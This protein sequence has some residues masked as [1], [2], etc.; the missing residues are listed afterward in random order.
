MRAWV[1]FAACLAATFLAVGAA[2]PSLSRDK[3]VWNYEGGLFV[4]TNGSIPNGPCFRLAGRRT[5]GGFFEHLKRIHRD[6]GTIFWPGAEE[7]Q[8]LPDQLN[9]AVVVHHPHHQTCA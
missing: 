1:H 7:G 2:S 4:I 9:L 6:D 3:N 8:N 5:S